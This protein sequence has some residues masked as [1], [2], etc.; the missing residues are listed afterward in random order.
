MKGIKWVKQG[1]AEEGFAAKPYCRESDGVTEN[2]TNQP[3]NS[4]PCTCP[5]CGSTNV[6]T[7]AGFCPGDDHGNHAAYGVFDKCSSCGFRWNEREESY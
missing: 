4:S 6:G 3:S 7:V 1:E 5:N 2:N